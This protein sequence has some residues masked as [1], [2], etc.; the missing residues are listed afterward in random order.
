LIQDRQ[1][2]IVVD[3]R[4]VPAMIPV[5]LRLSG[6]PDAQRSEWNFEVASHRA[7]T[8]LIVFTSIA[9]A[10]K[11]VA[12][13]HADV[14]FE[15]SSRVSFEGLRAPIELVDRGYSATGPSATSA[16][17]AIRAFDLIELAYGNPFVETRPTRIEIDLALRFAHE[18]TEIVDASVE[19]TEVDPGARIPV[20]VVLRPHAAPE[21]VRIV[22]VTI[23]ESAAGQTLPI[24]VEPGGAVELE[25]PEAR[26]LDD[27]IAA[28]RE[29]YGA[30]S[31]VVSLRLPQRGL[32]M[33]GHVVRALP[34]S[35]LDALQRTTDADRARP[36]MTHVRTEVP[37]GQ[38]LSGGARV[39]VQVRR[40]ARAE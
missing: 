17:Q 12:A 4:V 24:L 39:D 14:M 16:L 1:A 37:I 19:A 20:R 28:V 13:D 22:T 40:V 8:P 10:V 33:S 34:S 9:S 38:V 29:R 21:E 7:L 6:V 2:A 26:D 23:P 27:A 35:A 15:A 18:A 36:F 32:R 31:M 30:T 3:Q 5:R 25:R 11:S